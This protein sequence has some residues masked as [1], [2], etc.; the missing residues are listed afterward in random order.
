MCVF[1]QCFNG[2]REKERERE[3]E[4]ERDA[5]EEARCSFSKTTR[6]GVALK[7]SRCQ[8]FR[9][10]NTIEAIVLLVAVASL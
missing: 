5:V 8:L 7:C 4:K 3:R 10:R 1:S 2:M 6:S 9:L